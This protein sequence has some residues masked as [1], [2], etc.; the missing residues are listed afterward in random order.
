MTNWGRYAL[1][2]LS[3]LL[4][5]AAWPQ[6]GFG[7]LVLI[8]LIPWLF[9]VEGYWKSEAP[10]KFRLPFFFSTWL[11]FALFNGLTGWW[12]SLAH[13]SGLLAVVFIAASVE[14]L[15]MLLW[16]WVARQIG[17]RR[18]LWG[19]PFFW[20]MHEWVLDAWD[21]EWP[22]LKLGYAFADW[23]SWMQWYSMTGVYGGTLWIVAANVALLVFLRQWQKSR[24]WK[25]VAK[26]VLLMFAPVLLSLWMHAQYKEQG[27]AV[28]VVVVQ[29]NIEPYNEKFEMPVTQQLQIFFDQALPLVRPQTRYLVGPETMIPS[30][31]N[32]QK[33]QDEPLLRWVERFRNSLHDSL[34]V[35]IGINSL[36]IYDHPATASARPNREGTLWYDVYNTAIQLSEADSIP[37]YHKSKL[38]VGAEKMPFMEV[39]QPLLGELVLEFGGI[40]GTNRTQSHREVFVEDGG[41]MKVAPVI[42]WEAEFGDFVAD[43]VREGAQLLFAITNDGWWGDSEG[44]RQHL[45]YARVRAIETRRA[46]ARSANTGI[47]AFINQ[48]GDLL[49]TLG[50]EERGALRETI[51]ANTQKS[52]YVR[53]GDLLLRLA[54]LLVPLFVLYAISLKLRKVAPSKALLK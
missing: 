48:R 42:C 45:H 47:S 39:L 36:R 19:F 31:L 7:P 17:E 1:S 26:P 33:L 50:W 18:A 25:G 3:G 27:K 8:A 16:T 24:S 51:Y 28:E 34:H 9:A 32:E 46:M 29:P 35:V 22:W 41:R 13:W 30:G 53:Y 38:V 11:M 23:P 20:L 49:Q 6:Q 14:A 54:F 5:F 43:Y 15:W 21:M 37:V 2:A 10:R 44:H 4:L 12:I 52:L 40:S